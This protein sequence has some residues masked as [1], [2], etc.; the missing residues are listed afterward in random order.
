LLF[1]F[2]PLSLF[3]D[4]KIVSHYETGAVM[5]QAAQK[6]TS[7]MYIK[8]NK[9]RIDQSV[10]NTIVVDLDAKKMY[11]ID[12]SKKQIMEMDPDQ[13]KQASAMMGQL[14]AAAKTTVDIKK[15]GP[16]R[17]VNGFKCED[18]Q[19]NINGPVSMK[20]TQCISSDVSIKEFEP[21]RSFT[22]QFAQMIQGYD[23][24]KLQGMPIQSKGTMSLM[25]QQF[26]SNTEV[27]SI[28]HDSIPDSTFTLPSGYTT[29]EMPKMPT[30][31]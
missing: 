5:G 30:R 26:D 19:V 12:H 7:T 11:M 15:T 3:A 8:G 2:L 1:L 20:S 13:M 4:M 27:I 10:N 31:P 6:G 22:E 24:S 29:R 17:T 9:A 25:G 18:Y 14:G 16:E 23:M 21:F 28:S